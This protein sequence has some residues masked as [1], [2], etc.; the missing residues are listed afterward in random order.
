MFKTL[1]SFIILTHCFYAFSNRRLRIYEKN[2]HFTSQNGFTLS[3]IPWIK[4]YLY[5]SNSSNQRIESYLEKAVLEA[6]AKNFQGLNEKIL[7]R[8][9]GSVFRYLHGKKLFS[10][11][12]YKKSLAEFEKMNATSVLYPFSL[13][14]QAVIAYLNG[15]YLRSVEFYDSCNK[16][17]TDLLSNYQSGSNAYIQMKANRDVCI[18]GK[19]RTYYAQTK[20]E[21]ADSAY[22]DLDKGSIAWPPILIEEAWSSYYRKNYN[23][24]LGKLVTYGAPQL[25]FFSNPEVYVL[26][27]MSYLALCSYSDVS[28]TV[29]DFYKRF[30]P[31]AGILEKTISSYG[32]DKNYFFNMVDSFE[33]YPNE[34]LRFVLKGIRKLPS[35]KGY[36]RNIKMAELEKRAALKVNNSIIRKSLIANAIEFI[37]S[38]Q[39]V[40]GIA[41]KAKLEKYAYDLRKSFQAM[42]YMRLEV[43][44]RK[45][46]SLYFDT[47][48][49]K[50][51]GD[52]KYLK[53]TEKQY[54]W[55]FIYE[56]WS[57]ELGDY[58][59]TLP[60]ECPDE[61]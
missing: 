9:S 57:D 7:E 39:A 34:E 36:L 15:D 4:E 35:I 14:F 3:V 54:F 18:V 17:S 8:N 37:N 58:V 43:L 48:L 47:K 2:I 19:A 49:T 33:N 52:V 59:F 41:A 50:K 61:N 46:E 27:A 31:V 23:R 24:T 5:L 10:Q 12:Q 29:E 22:L 13:N 40:I 44:G 21:K 16:A 56:F 30:E 60:S 38:Q 26:R 28:L 20:Y 32:R 53:K 45:K 42:S 51:R 11:G 55:D 6:G 25:R 1:I